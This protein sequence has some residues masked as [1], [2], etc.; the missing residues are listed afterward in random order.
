MVIQDLGRRHLQPKRFRGLTQTSDRKNR[1]SCERLPFPIYH[2]PLQVN[3]LPL[4]QGDDFPCRLKSQTPVCRGNLHC[5]NRGRQLTEALSQVPDL[6]QG[7][8]I[9]PVPPVGEIIILNPVGFEWEHSWLGVAG[10]LR[11]RHGQGRSS[12]SK[13]GYIVHLG[14]LVV[15]LGASTPPQR[16][17]D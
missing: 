3:Y 10:G 8:I 16:L 15:V 9:D 7:Y 17:V 1:F 14:W 5:E 13:Q 2:Q 6:R 11:I 4:C 12:F